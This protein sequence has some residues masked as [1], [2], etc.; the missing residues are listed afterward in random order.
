[1][2]ELIE[3]ER[4]GVGGN[5]LGDDIGLSTD[6]ANV[7]R[8]VFRTPAARDEDPIHISYKTSTYVWEVAEVGLWKEG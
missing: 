7:E 4:P 6:L 5:R 8:L 3:E 1:M 2:L